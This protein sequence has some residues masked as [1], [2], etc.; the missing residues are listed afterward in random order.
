[1]SLFVHP[2]NQQL[3]WNIVNSNV[4]VNQFFESNPN[5]RK[6]EWFKQMIEFFYKKLD[7]KEI[8]YDE[9]NILNK[10]ALTYMVQN[11]HNSSPTFSSSIQ[12]IKPQYSENKNTIQTP[13]IPSNTREQEYTNDFKSREQEYASMIETKKPS[14]IDFSEKIDE[15][16]I[17]NMDELL[18]TQLKERE[19]YLQHY[20][21][22]PIDPN[23]NLNNNPQSIKMDNSTNII[24]EPDNL[25]H[26][27]EKK[28]S[29]KED[30]EPNTKLLEQSIEN[31]IYDE[32]KSLQIQMNTIVSKMNDMHTMI[33]EGFNV[34]KKNTEVKTI[35]TETNAEL[36]KQKLIET[37]T[38][39]VLLETV[40]SESD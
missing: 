25:Q 8:N 22:P 10:D 12:Y 29:W 30:R 1:M 13:P 5:V 32:I 20:N 11:I 9:L 24:I 18:K 16:P 15:R 2:E 23:N 33:Q 34:Y 38:N 17:Q 21:V 37:N 39:E 4:Y 31:P 40:E 6:E 7:Q 28:V 26:S 14:E 35:Q 3:L 19:S 36:I 27:N